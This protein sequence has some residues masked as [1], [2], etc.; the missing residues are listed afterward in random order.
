MIVFVPNEVIKCHVLG[1]DHDHFLIS[2][3]VKN[4]I[5][6][7]KKLFIIHNYNDL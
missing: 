1:C 5:I 6:G 7:N 4:I 2:V 3:S